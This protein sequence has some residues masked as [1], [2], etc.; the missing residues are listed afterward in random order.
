M[1]RRPRRRRGA[2]AAAGGWRGASQVA[3]RR[4]EEEEAEERR[5]AQA[6]LAVETKRMPAVV[7]RRLRPVGSS[8]R[9]SSQM[10]ASGRS[11]CG[12]A[13]VWPEGV[14]GCH[15]R[16]GSGPQHGSCPRGARGAAKA[17][18][19]GVAPQRDLAG[20]HAAMAEE[21]M[22]L[23]KTDRVDDHAHTHPPRDYTTFYS[24]SIHGVLKFSPRPTARKN[25]ILN[26]MYCSE[27]PCSCA[28]LQGQLMSA[29]FAEGFV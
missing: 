9:I 14:D 3:S 12:A 2:Q 13:Q 20:S 1:W 17:H 15:H 18:S 24:Y 26:P 7:L 21:E 29:G 8:I 19:R 4:G 25:I 10:S 22:E 27:S 11:F 6:P 5:E 28:P 23:F 16:E